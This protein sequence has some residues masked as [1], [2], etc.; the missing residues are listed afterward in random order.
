MAV[1]VREGKDVYSC[2]SRGLDSEYGADNNPRNHAR[3]P[4]TEHAGIALISTAPIKREMKPHRGVS[5]VTIVV[6]QQLNKRRRR[7]I[8]R[9][10]PQASDIVLELDQHQQGEA[11]TPQP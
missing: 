7:D 2:C 5:E 1:E 3:R 4:V 11:E 10:R 6:V 8:C 9:V